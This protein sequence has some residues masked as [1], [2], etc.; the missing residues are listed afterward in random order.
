MPGPYGRMQ[1]RA[2]VAAGHPAT[3]EVGAEIL[4]EGGT[5]AD[6]VVAMSSGLLRRRDGDERPSLR[7]S[8]DRLRRL[9]GVERR[10]LRGAAFGRR[11]SPGRVRTLRRRDRRLLD[12]A[13]LVCG[14]RP[15]GDARRA[16]RATAVGCPGN[17]SSSPRST[18]PATVSRSRRCTGARSRCSPNVL[19]LERGGEIFAP[20]GQ[21]LAGGSAARAARPRHSARDAGRRGGRRP[22]IAVRSPKTLLRGG[23]RGLHGRRPCRATR[24]AG[25]IRVLTDFHGR[26]VATRGGLSGMPELLPR[27]PRL[28]GLSETE[29]VLALVAALEVPATGGEHTTNM[30][31]PSTP[32]AA[33]A[34]SPTRSVSAPESGF[35]VSTCS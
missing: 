28:A 2:G 4:A 3:A 18:S 5:A 30:S 15:S 12:R 24:L 34:S 23:R 29:R 32:R 31:S 25:R 35:P 20:E 19:T 33:P 7:L 6:A 11:R 8:C 21:L 13:R 17:G 10:R 16:L 22:S 14:S 27:L 26:R 1:V 9:P